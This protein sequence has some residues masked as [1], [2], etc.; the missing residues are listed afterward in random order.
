VPHVERGPVRVDR[1]GALRD[2]G[3]VRAH[4]VDLRDLVG[5]VLVGE[6]PREP[7]L[8]GG[9]QGVRA[10]VLA[11][12]HVDPARIRGEVADPEL[13]VVR[14]HRALD[15]GDDRLDRGEVLGVLGGVAGEPRA[16]EGGHAPEH[17]ASSGLEVKGELIRAGDTPEPAGQVRGMQADATTP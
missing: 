14:V 4:E 8:V 11:A 13:G 2:E 7:G 17:R 16:L 9:E 12:A 10:A 15:V 3:D 6:R 5:G 1:G